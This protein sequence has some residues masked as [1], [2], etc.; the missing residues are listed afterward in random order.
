MENTLD[1]GARGIDGGLVRNIGL[2]D[3][4]PWIASV[5]LQVGA[6][7]HYEAVEHTHAPAFSHQAIDKMTADK[8]RTT[9]DQIK[10]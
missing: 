2:D 5:L 10:A 9:G 1:A 6:A 4:D 7:A 8:S 3:L